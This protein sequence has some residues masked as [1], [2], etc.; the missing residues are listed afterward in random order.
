MTINY[1]DSKYES[2]KD[3]YLKKYFCCDF[4]KKYDLFFVFICALG[5]RLLFWKIFGTYMSYFRVDSMEYYQTSINFEPPEIIRLLL[6]YNYWYERTPAY[7]L[8]LHLIHREIF[9]Q[10]IIS[11][12]SVVLLYRINKIAGWLWCFYLQ[13]IMYSFQYAKESLLLFFIILS[14]YYLKNNKR[15]LII[16]IPLIIIPF[17]S[18]GGVIRFNHNYGQG[19]LSNLWN[20]WKP[21]FDITVVYSKWFVYLQVIPYSI[22]FFYFLRN[23]KLFSLEFCI[24]AGL[25]IVYGI[26]YGQ[27]RYREPFMPLLLLYIA[28]PLF[29]YCK[30]LMKRLKEFYVVTQEFKYSPLL[31]YKKVY[32][33]GYFYLAKLIPK[34]LL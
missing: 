21:A 28:D 15:W 20:L 14:I 29:V 10:I 6:G 3:Y 34:T 24:A 11:S 16:L 4:L 31:L 2:G 19:F 26:I 30:N 5:V 25:S 27:P 23:V 12:F 33:S 18:F 9:I 8:F 1:I 22:V 13:E 7:I 32:S 17:S